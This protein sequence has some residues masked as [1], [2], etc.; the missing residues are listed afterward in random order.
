MYA[1]A[2]R[3]TVKN[4]GFFQSGRLQTLPENPANVGTPPFAAALVLTVP[5]VGLLLDGTEACGTGML[6]APP[7]NESPG[8]LLAYAPF[9]ITGCGAG[10]ATTAFAGATGTNCPLTTAEN[11]LTASYQSESR[12]P[13]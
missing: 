6:V 5:V 10:G 4:N 8:K 7:M 3:T 9:E 1:T 11:V 13:A 2:S 12:I